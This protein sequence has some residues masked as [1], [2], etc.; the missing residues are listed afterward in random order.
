LSA[1]GGQ[2]PVKTANDERPTINGVF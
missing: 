1:A 2:L